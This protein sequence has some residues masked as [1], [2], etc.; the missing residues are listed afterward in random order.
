MSNVQLVHSRT[1]YN[2]MDLVGD[3]GGVQEVFFLVLGALIAPYAEHSF[4]LEAIRKLYLVRTK[5][6]HLFK[7][8]KS[9]RQIKRELRR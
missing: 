2:F 8:P 4:T 9:E 6:N 1:V 5:E 3:Y 7:K